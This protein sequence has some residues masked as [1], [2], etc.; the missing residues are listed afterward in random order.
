MRLSCDRWP[1]HDPGTPCGR[2]FD[3]GDPDGGGVYPTKHKTLGEG[4]VTRRLDDGTWQVGEWVV[5]HMKDGYRPDPGTVVLVHRQWDI[6][7]TGSFLYAQEIKKE[8]SE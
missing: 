2:C 8:E 6:Y 1:P 5:A 3:T 7:G 4:V